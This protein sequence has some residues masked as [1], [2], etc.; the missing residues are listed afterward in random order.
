VNPPKKVT[1]GE[2]MKAWLRGQS[3][4]LDEG[5]SEIQLG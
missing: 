3:P 2:K 1:R 4:L 5:Q